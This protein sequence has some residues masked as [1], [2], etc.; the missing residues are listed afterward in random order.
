MFF[1]CSVEDVDIIRSTILIKSAEIT[2]LLGSLFKITKTGNNTSNIIA[3]LVF[4]ITPYN[5]TII[6]QL[7]HHKI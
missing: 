2:T 5:T 6:L 4:I 7:V 3:I 1:T